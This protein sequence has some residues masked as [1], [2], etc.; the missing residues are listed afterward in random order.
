MPCQAITALWRRRCEK[1]PT[2]I[3]DS[4]GAESRCCAQASRRLAW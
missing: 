3:R 4:L 2:D 1:T